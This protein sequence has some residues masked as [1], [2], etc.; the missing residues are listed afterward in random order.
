[1][2]CAERQNGLLNSEES[3]RFNTMSETTDSSNSEKSYPC[4]GCGKPLRRIEGKKGPFWGCSDFPQCKT[5]RYDLDGVPSEDPDE[6]YRCPVCTRSLVKSDK[7]NADYW[8]C[9]GY[10]KGCKV[11]LKDINGVPEASY[12][13]RQCGSLLNKRRGKNGEFWGCKAY[14]DCTATYADSDNGPKF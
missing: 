14:P 6:H 9:S 7:G 2:D 5:T 3:T 11:T 4:P 10:G 1:M 13:C 8:F 12:R